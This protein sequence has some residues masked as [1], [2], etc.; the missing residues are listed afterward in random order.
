MTNNLAQTRIFADG[1]ASFDGDEYT[2]AVTATGT[3]DVELRIIKDQLYVALHDLALTATPGN[4]AIDEFIAT[5][6]TIKEVW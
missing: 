4:D 2:T 5:I 1:H 3:I 6:P